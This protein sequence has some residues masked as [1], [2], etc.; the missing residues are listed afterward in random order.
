MLKIG[1]SSNLKMRKKLIL[2][3]LDIFIPFNP[4]IHKE[5]MFNH[6]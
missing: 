5:K 6:K 2:P 4:L 3:N 1:Y